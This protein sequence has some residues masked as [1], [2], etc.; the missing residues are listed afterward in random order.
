MTYKFTKLDLLVKDRLLRYPSLFPNR[1][2]ALRDIFGRGVW[3]EDG[4]IDLDPR[5]LITSKPAT[6]ENYLSYFVSE[7]ERSKK[8]KEENCDFDDSYKSI[9]DLFNTRIL[10]AEINLAGAKI[11]LENIDLITTSINYRIKETINCVSLNSIINGISSFSINPYRTYP[12]CF[13]NRTVPKV[14]NETVKKEIIDWLNA[15]LFHTTTMREISTK[16]EKLLITIKELK[17][18]YNG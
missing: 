18:Y 9:H 7:L 14:V 6:P 2:L 3:T 8:D 17:E 11:V 1:F 10:E 13:P 4:E 12:S 5:D 15:I 16:V